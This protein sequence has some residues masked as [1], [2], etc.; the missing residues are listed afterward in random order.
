MLPALEGKLDGMAIRVP[1]PNVSLVDLTVKLDKAA[2]ADEVNKA[3]HK[4][5]AS[6]PKGDVSVEALKLLASAVDVVGHT[7]RE[8][9]M[10]RLAKVVRKF[11]S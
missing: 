11:H 8:R 2:N 1:T 6:V 10:A 9:G 7:P 5:L 4:R 3:F